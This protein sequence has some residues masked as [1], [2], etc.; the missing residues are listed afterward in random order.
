MHLL[1]SELIDFRIPM[2]WEIQIFRG[3]RTLCCALLNIM[4]SHDTDIHSHS[5]AFAFAYFIV[6]VLYILERYALGDFGKSKFGSQEFLTS[7]RGV[8]LAVS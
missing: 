7:R 3:D 1:A 2:C 4:D 6:Y 8:W 5:N